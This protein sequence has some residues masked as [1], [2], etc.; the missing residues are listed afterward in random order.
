MKELKD[1]LNL[2]VTNHN[3]TNTVLNGSLDAVWICVKSL[4]NWRTAKQM[5]CKKDYHHGWIFFSTST[6]TNGYNLYEEIKEACKDKNVLVT[7][8]DL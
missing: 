1:K 4:E 8:R 7:Y 5:G 3:L 2:I 6:N